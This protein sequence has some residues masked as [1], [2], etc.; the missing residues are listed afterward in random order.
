MLLAHGYAARVF[1]VLERAR[2][3]VDVI[4]TSEVSI[5]VTVDSAVSIDRILREL[6]SFADVEVRRG[7]GV[8]TVVGQRLRSTS[9]VGAR[10][11][12]ALGD[13]NVLLVSQGASETNVTFVVEEET[14]G[15]AMNRLHDEF[16]G[17]ARVVASAGTGAS[18]AAVSAEAAP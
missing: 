8:L 16:F 11:F 10:I 1:A 4:A 17:A 15:A 5:A 7:L 14:L 18:D 9:G 12:R 2:V 13:I 3:A 6:E